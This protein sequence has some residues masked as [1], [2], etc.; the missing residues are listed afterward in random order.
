M[1]RSQAKGISVSFGKKIFQSAGALIKLKF[2]VV[3]KNKSIVFSVAMDGMLQPCSAARWLRALWCPRCRSPS[4]A[5]FQ[6]L[7]ARRS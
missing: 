6:C 3:I 4:I 2:P 1:V 7:C 5:I